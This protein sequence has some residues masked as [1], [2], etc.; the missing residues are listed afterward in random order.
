MKSAPSPAA[1]A[2]QPRPQGAPPGPEGRGPEA[3]PGLAPSGEKKVL[4]TKVWG[5]VKWFNVRNGY[6]FINR[7]DTKEDVF[8]HQTAIK[9]NNPRK[10]LRSVGD[11]EPVEFDVVE[12]EKGVEAANVTGPGGAPV[13]GSKYAADRSEYRRGP[14]RPPPQAPRKSRPGERPAD[15][16]PPPAAA[17]E[18][19]PW[20]SG[21][22]RRPACPLPSARRAQ[23]VALALRR[24]PADGADTELAAGGEQGRGG[25]RG[26]LREARPPL[27]GAG[28]GRW[29]PTARAEGPEDD[30]EA[31][32]G[33]R[34]RSQQSPQRRFR[35]HFSYQHRRPGNP[36]PPEARDAKAALHADIAAQ[37]KDSGLEG[38]QA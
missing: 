10:Y 5:T 15:G 32:K 1:G 9:K 35:R 31:H 6:G 12:G 36:R 26:G 25:R 20:K 8:V 38:G 24:G 29:G 14:A 16:A 34:I 21:A 2:A 30:K 22:P 37:A 13:Q 17:A 11:G 4:A 3:A 33:K 23:Y 28:A 18:P 7:D 27:R 19:E